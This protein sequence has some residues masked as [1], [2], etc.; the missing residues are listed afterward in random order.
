MLVDKYRPSKLK[1]ILLDTE[2]KKNIVQLSKGKSLPNLIFYGTA[3]NGKTTTARALCD[4]MGIETYE[5]NASIE[6]IDVIRT[7]LMNYGT[8]V[9]LT[10]RGKCIILDE[11]DNMSKAM[12]QALRGTIETLQKNCTFILTANYIDRILDPIQSRCTSFDFSIDPDDSQLHSDTMALVK[13]ICR[14]EKKKFTDGDVNLLVTQYFPD[15]RSVINNLDTATK[16]GTLK[17]TR[18][19]APNTTGSNVSITV[20][21]GKILMKRPESEYWQAKILV[22]G[23]RR[24]ERRSLRTTDKKLAMKRLNE[25][26]VRVTG[27]VDKSTILTLID[28]MQN[29][30]KTLQSYVKNLP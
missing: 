2:L 22:P 30:L 24:Y 19:Q 9:S 1:D 20:A 27:Q 13:K 18:A 3:G 12:Q 23:T 17:L 8:T 15:I 26:Y 11:A 14:K 16:S 6:G 28:K 7:K 25:E 4:Q 29:E 21:T 10:S 5:V